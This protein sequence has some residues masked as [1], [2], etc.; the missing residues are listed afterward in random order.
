MIDKE[1]LVT[2]EQV[3]EAERM[4]GVFSREMMEV[5]NSSYGQ[6]EEAEVSDV[7]ARAMT[8]A[9]EHGADAMVESLNDLPKAQQAAA[10]TTPPWEG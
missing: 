5:I 4:V 7:L 10:S 1:K 3:Q 6:P 8:Q 9:F 2:P